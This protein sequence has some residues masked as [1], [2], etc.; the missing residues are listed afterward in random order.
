VAGATVTPRAP[1][2]GTGLAATSDSS[3]PSSPLLMV[4]GL[5]VL[6]GGL[7]LVAAGRRTA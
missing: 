2:S 3:S 5:L 7:F 1:G 4:A 6:T